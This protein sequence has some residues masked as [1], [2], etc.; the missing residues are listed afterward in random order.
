ME[1]LR[2]AIRELASLPSPKV[3]DRL[4]AQLGAAPASAELTELICRTLELTNLHELRDSRGVTVRWRLVDRLLALG[5]PH[6]LQVTPE[7]LDYHRHVKPSGDQLALRTLTA[8]MGLISVL[9]SSLLSLLLVMGASGTGLKGLGAGAALL[10]SLGH[11]V[12]AMV[13]AIG[14]HHSQ[15]RKLLR[16]LGW[17]F[18][19]P[20]AVAAVSS[21]TTDH[22]G[23]FSL[24]VGA[25][26]MLTAVLCGLLA[27]MEPDFEPEEVAAPRVAEPERD[28]VAPLPA[29]VRVR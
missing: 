13:T 11:G 21:V 16:P 24:V 4:V 29:K 27:A 6:A 9:W 25:P 19:F 1:E 26:M 12:L 10:V 22:L 2:F 28:E 23:F 20:L 17:S 15:P 7:D 5:F 18:F 3:A 8:C 14:G